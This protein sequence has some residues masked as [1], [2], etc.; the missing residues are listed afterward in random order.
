MVEKFGEETWEQLRY[1]CEH[2]SLICFRVHFPVQLKSYFLRLLAEVQDT[3]M[4][5]EIYDDVITIRLVQEACKM[6]GETIF[7]HVPK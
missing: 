6:L 5:Y 3:F 7:N 2:F 4:T 1:V